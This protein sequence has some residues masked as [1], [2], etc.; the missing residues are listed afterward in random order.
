MVFPAFFR[1]DTVKSILGTLEE[2][3]LFL[4]MLL[5]R[6]EPLIII[7]SFLWIGIVCLF[8]KY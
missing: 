8:V 7:K 1:E 2:E 3:L 4:N 6:D 5:P